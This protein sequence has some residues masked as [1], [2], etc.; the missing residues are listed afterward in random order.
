MLY[1]LLIHALAGV[2]ILTLPISRPPADL[3]EA[4]LFMLDALPAMG[5]TP[6]V[7]DAEIANGLESKLQPNTHPKSSE[8]VKRPAAIIVSNPRNATNGFQTILQPDL[9]DR[10]L[11]KK[12]VALPNTLMVARRTSHGSKRA[13]AQAAVPVL[14]APTSAPAILRKDP[15]DAGGDSRHDILALS[16]A[17]TPPSDVLL[18]PT[19]EARGQLILLSPP[20]PAAS[21]PQRATANS[22]PAPS[23]F[24]GITIQGGEWDRD[25]PA[26][27]TRLVGSRADGPLDSPYPLTVAAAGNSGGGLRDFGVFDNQPVY[28]DYLPIEGLCDPH[29]PPL[30]LQFT[31]VDSSH[32]GSAALT[33]PRPVSWLLPRW[34]EEAAV[35]Y[36]GEMIVVFAVIAEDGRIRDSRVME[37]PSADLSGALLNALAQWTFRP[38]AINAQP[39]AVKV[40]LGIP[41]FPDE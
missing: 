20:N 28:T 34:P 14:P 38:A 6:G 11:L 9:A 30:V 16:I 35:G 15:N 17:P 5:S 19:A 41:V 36:E 33:H 31:F 10:R 7:S 8:R 39:A 18:I 25:S 23:A 26:A 21:D 2:T 1:S 12:F 4:N 32:D 22:A 29:A 13:V 40:L 3:F 27:E 37:S 24:A